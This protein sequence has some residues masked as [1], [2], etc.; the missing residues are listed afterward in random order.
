IPSGI[1]SDPT[2]GMILLGITLSTLAYLSDEASVEMK[3]QNRNL[4]RT[5]ANTLSFSDSKSKLK[6]SDLSST[7]TSESENSSRSRITNYSLVADTGIKKLN[8]AE[9]K[10]KRRELNII[11]NRKINYFLQKYANVKDIDCNRVSDDIMQNLNISKN[12][13]YNVLRFIR[14]TMNISPL[15]YTQDN[16]INVVRDIYENSY[17]HK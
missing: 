11:Y 4:N 17:S 7:S 16:F 9:E 3:L 15:N 8:A 14:N 2:I 12:E 10:R 6:A 1:L 5:S 13:L